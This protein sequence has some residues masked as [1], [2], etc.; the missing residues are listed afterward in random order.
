MGCDTWLAGT[1]IG[2]ELSMEICGEECLGI[3]REMSLGEC[4]GENVQIPHA[5]LQFSRCSS[6]DLCHTDTL[7]W[8]TE[9]TQKWVSS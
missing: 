2:R 5:G 7:K 1:Q 4:L 6:F 8:L 3:V 9:W